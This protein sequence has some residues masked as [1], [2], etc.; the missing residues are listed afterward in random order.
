MKIGWKSG[1]GK[2]MNFLKCYSKNNFWK[3][4]VKLYLC[5][6]SVLN[7]AQR[8][9]LGSGRFN[10]EEETSGILGIGH[11]PHLVF[12]LCKIIPI[13]IRREHRMSI[14]WPFT[15]LTEIL[16]LIFSRGDVINSTFV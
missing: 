15:V 16:W 12:V 8:S 9:R 1:I 5:I 13:L 14:P 3:M 7:G 6:T 10:P 11:C 4:K 2:Q